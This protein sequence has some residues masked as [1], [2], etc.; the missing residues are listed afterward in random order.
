MTELAWSESIGKR[1]RVGEWAD[2]AVPTLQKAREAMAEAGDEFGL[3]AGR[4]EVAAQLV[5]YFMEEA[6]VV[7]LIYEVWTQGFL[8]YLE[9]RG[10]SED[11]RTAELERLQ[12]LLAY[13]DGT[14]LDPVARW[15]ALG[16]RA[17]RLGNRIRAYRISVAAASEEMAALG[18]DWRM[19]HDRY[20]D[21]MAGVLAFVAKRFGETSLEDCYRAVLEPYI[22]ERY[23]VFDTREHPYE[24][25]IERNLYL[26]FEAMRAHMCGPDRKGDLEYEE[27][28]DRYV[29]SFDPC[30]SG[31]RSMR[32]DHIEGTGSRVLAPYEFGVTQGEYD[33]AWNEQGICYYCAH[34]AMTL[35]K[36]PM[37]RWGEPV[38]VVDPPRWNGSA[39]DVERQKCSWT[40]YK[41]TEQIPEW[42]YERVGHKKPQ[43]PVIQ[44]DASVGR[45]DPT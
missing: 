4:R 14:P 1:V 41:S 10:V 15:D 35:E 38:R 45:S 25:T 30:G 43:L 21:V 16:E 18:E 29:V 44:P 32:G 6:K 26:T 24:S 28:D 34:C 39:E 33:W 13:P 17:G 9:S 40:V 5:D 19:L 31:G 20:A 27:F 36:L 12:A 3:K 11:E 37:E 2:Q 42:V 7:Y 23:M 22:Q 8:D